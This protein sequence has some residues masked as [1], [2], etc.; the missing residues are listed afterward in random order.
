MGLPSTEWLVRPVAPIDE[1]TASAVLAARFGVRGSVRDLG[2]QQDRNYRVRG[3]AG[4]TS[5]RSPTPPPRRPS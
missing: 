4:S 1:A 5:S 3:D 2:S